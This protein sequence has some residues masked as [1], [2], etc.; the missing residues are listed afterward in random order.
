MNAT[1][2]IFALA[3]ASN[4]NPQPNFQKTFAQIQRM[5]T[6]VFSAVYLIPCRDG[7][8]ADYWNAACLLKSE[9]TVDE[10]TAILKKMEAD[11]GRVRPSHHISLDIDLIAWG[12]DLT[13]MTF[14]PKKLPLALDVKIPMMEIWQD[15]Q[16]RHA[17]HDFPQ[18]SLNIQ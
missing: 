9:L 1:E 5:G 6:S 16:F 3:L 2:T 13:A 11:S 7:I 17:E 4:C 15:D 14:N 12:R 8:G 10:M 18:V